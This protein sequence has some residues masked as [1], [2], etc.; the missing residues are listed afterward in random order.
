MTTLLVK[1]TELYIA[2]LL[3]LL[4]ARRA[5]A[6][7]RHLQC[8]CVLAGSLLL[9]LLLP[10]KL[11]RKPLRQPRQLRLQ[12]LRK[13]RQPRL[14]SRKLQVNHRWAKLLKSA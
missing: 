6:T 10:L 7:V 4:I 3:T 12:L 9:P 11:L 2:G 5:G 1:V 13:P 8:V 14:Q